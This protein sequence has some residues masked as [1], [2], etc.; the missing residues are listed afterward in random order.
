[1]TLLLPPRAHAPSRHP[2]SA[3]V[4]PTCAVKKSATQVVSIGQTEAAA[5]FPFPAPPSPPAVPPRAAVSWLCLS[6]FGT[7][8]LVG[9]GFFCFKVD[10]QTERAAPACGWVSRAGVLALPRVGCQ[11]IRKLTCCHARFQEA[12]R[13]TNGVHMDEG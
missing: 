9:T 5:P 2:A 1:M 4:R 7:T 6:L 12:L 13:F 11:T 3:R 10:V 8:D